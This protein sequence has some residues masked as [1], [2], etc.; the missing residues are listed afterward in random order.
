MGDPPV[1]PQHD[2]PDNEDFG[3]TE[4]VGDG[5]PEEAQRE[6]VPE[7]SDPDHRFEQEGKDRKEG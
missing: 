1:A 7:G 3:T 4:G 6:A 5:Y 2:Q